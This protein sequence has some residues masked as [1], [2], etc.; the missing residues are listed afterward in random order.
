MTSFDGMH[1]FLWTINSKDDN[2]CPILATNDTFKT[3]YDAAVRSIFKVSS[4][5]YSY[6]LYSV[7]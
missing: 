7:E 3:L 4:E 6:T 2:F 5:Q 1:I